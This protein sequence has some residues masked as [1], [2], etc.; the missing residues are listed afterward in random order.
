[1]RLGFPSCF[2]V[3]WVVSAV[4]LCR[5]F[6][7]N[8]YGVRKFLSVIDIHSHIIAGVDDGAKTWEIAQQMCRMAAA[9]GIEHMVATASRQ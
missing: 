3:S 8:R 6:C 9:D 4:G 2:L 5:S 7:L 1:M